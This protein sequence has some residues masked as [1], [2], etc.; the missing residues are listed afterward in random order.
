MEKDGQA[1]RYQDELGIQD[2]INTDVKGIG[3]LG[4][5]GKEQLRE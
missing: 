1:G 5:D 4:L 2:C 3:S